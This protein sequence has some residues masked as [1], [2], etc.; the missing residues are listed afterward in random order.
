M[1]SF[2][3]MIP[4]YSLTIWE[5]AAEPN[6]QWLLLVGTA[7]LLPIIFANTAYTYWVFRGKVRDDASY[8]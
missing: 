4:P 8:H 1:Q 6:S 3:P 2:D 5:A 7:F